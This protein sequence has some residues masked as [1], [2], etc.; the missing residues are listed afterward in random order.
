MVGLDGSTLVGVAADAAWPPVNQVDWKAG[1]SLITGALLAVAFYLAVRASCFQFF[2]RSN[3]CSSCTA[4]L[5]RISVSIES[6]PLLDGLMRSDGSRGGNR[7]VQVSQQR[8]YPSP[9]PRARSN[10]DFMGARPNSP[11]R[12]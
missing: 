4:L 2:I 12:R 9:P 11:P 1:A 5:E 6:M 7:K 10:R 3:R 8:G